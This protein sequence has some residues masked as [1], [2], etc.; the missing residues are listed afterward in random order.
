MCYYEGHIVAS[1][2]LLTTWNSQSGN[3]LAMAPV[4]DTSQKPRLVVPVAHVSSLI[5]KR[6]VPHYLDTQ[7]FFTCYCA[8]KKK[9]FYLTLA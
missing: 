4:E 6:L 5:I 3:V 2:W 1:T 7:C 8:R 9:M